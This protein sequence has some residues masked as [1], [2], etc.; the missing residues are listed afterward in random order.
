MRAMFARRQNRNMVQAALAQL[1]LVY[2][3]TV[4]N[5]RRGHRNAFAG[6]V[7]QV[8]QSLIMIGAF[9]ALFLV[10]GLR[11]SPVRG[12]FLIFMMTGIF[13]F[14]VHVQTMSSVAMSG[15][16]NMA[17]TK[18]EPMT[19]AVLITAAALST[20]YQQVLASAV[21]LGGY[22]VIE[23]FSIADPVGAMGMLLLAWASGAAIGLVLLAL[24]PWAP[25]VIPLIMRL[26]QRANMVFS[27]K[28]FLANLMPGFM[29]KMFIWNPLFHICDQARGFAFINYTPMKTSLSFP[30]YVTLALTMLGLLLE[31]VT[32]KHQ[33]LSWSAA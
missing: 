29:L 24:I 30:I 28:M 13:M 33:S 25:S 21:I 3:Q 18:H 5:L 12:D 9:M 22:Y 8:I 11:S 26:I 17:M 2:H 19:T 27:G 4:A 6:L 32:R 23:P 14:R 1:Q 20:L 15:R 7:I 31:F 10:M 16:T